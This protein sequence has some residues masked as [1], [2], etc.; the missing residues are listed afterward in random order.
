MLAVAL[1]TM[2]YGL[3]ANQVSASSCAASSDTI[4]LL[5]SGTSWSIHA[6]GFKEVIPGTQFA[7]EL[8]LCD[9]PAGTEIIEATASMPA[10]GH[11]MNYKPEINDNA[12]GDIVASGWLMHM[13]GEWE[14][15][16]R[17]RLGSDYHT[18]TGEVT[19]S[20]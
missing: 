15:R 3:I 2:V 4:E 7:V 16:V 10:H 11:G 20:P 9:A 6:R 8:A 19:V 1:M 14:I 17:T 12:H 13:A 5:E 18:F